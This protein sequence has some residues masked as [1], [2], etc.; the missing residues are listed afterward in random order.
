MYAIRSYYDNPELF[1]RLQRRTTGGVTWGGDLGA[2]HESNGAREPDSRSWNRLYL[3][4]AVGYRGLWAELKLWYR[5]EEEVK[6]DPNDPT[7]D[8]NP[9]IEDFYGHGELRLAYTTPGG[10]RLGAMGRYNFAIV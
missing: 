5:L 8:E 9:D 7:G 2:E 6:E 1:Y 4:P 10:H 3:A